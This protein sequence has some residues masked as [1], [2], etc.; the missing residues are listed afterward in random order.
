MERL[1]KQIEFIV[2]ADK[3]KNIVRMNYNASGSRRENDA[4]H[5]WHFALMAIAL[6]EYTNAPVDL[7][8]VVKMALIHDLVEIDAGDAYVYDEQARAAQR[9]KELKAAERIFN[10]LPPDQAAE[11]R[12]LWDEFEEKSTP[13]AKFANAIDRMHPM[14]M[15]YASEGRS[16]K[17]NGITGDMVENKNRHIAEGSEKLWEYC[18]ENILKP[19]REKGYF[20]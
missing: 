13:E 11:Y 18:L 17:E 3:I 10:L 4:E 12:R 6:Y 20:G 19:A 15:N 14:L 2:E 8:K 5:S 16:W 1:K 7:M 9:E